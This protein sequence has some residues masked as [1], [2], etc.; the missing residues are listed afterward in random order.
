MTTS[1]QLSIILIILFFTLILIKEAVYLFIGSILWNLGVPYHYI[2]EKAKLYSNV[3]K[4][5][6]FI[7]IYKPK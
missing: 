2:L 3:L 5:K 1:E 4:M 6:L 7:F